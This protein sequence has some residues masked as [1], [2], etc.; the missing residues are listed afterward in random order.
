MQNFSLQQLTWPIQNAKD[1]IY[2]IERV[3]INGHF[4]TPCQE[5]FTTSHSLYCVCTTW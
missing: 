2:F 3:F 5:A 1:E 4:D